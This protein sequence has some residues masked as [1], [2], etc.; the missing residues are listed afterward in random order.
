MSLVLVAL[1]SLIGT[2]WSLYSLASI[3]KWWWKRSW[4]KINEII[5]IDKIIWLV[6]R[7][8]DCQ[9][10][11]TVPRLSPLMLAAIYVIDLLRVKIASLHPNPIKPSTQTSAKRKIIFADW[12]NGGKEMWWLYRPNKYNLNYLIYLINIFERL[13]KL[14]E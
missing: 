11:K 6:N 4:V 9:G 2:D 12:K 13:K 14:A 1:E 3:L 7:H 5:L 10:D 8:E